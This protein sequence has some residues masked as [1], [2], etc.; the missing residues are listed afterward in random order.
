MNAVTTT[1][2]EP[3]IQA[4]RRTGLNILLWHVHGSWTTSF[5]HGP[6]RYL[7]PVLPDGSTWGRGRAGRD[8]PANVHE[9]PAAELRGMDVDVVV[10]QRPEEFR[11]ARDW[12]GRRVPGDVPAVYVEHDTPYGHAAT[13]RH[14]IAERNDIPLI[15]VTYFNELMWDNGRAP[16]VVIPHGIV[17]PGHL[18]TGEL[19]RAAATIDEADPDGRVTGADLL[20]GFATVAPVDAYGIGAERIGV[21]GVTG[22]GALPTPRLHRELAKRRVYVH[23][24]RWTSLGLSL[25]EAMQLGMPVVAAAATEAAVAVPPEAG[26]V[27]SDVTVLHQAVRDFMNDP[28]LAAEYGVRAREYALAGFGLPAFLTAWDALLTELAR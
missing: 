5:V 4:P 13:T 18:Y 28:D 11:L 17:D 15:H 8:W 23:T 9:V 2:T 3:E 1:A 12:L 7:L 19:P 25:V 10:L 16:T 27:S 6:H 14:H 20:R 26:I 21:P 22:A 24:S